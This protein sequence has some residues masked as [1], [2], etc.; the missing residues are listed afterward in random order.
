MGTTLCADRPRW[1]VHFHGDFRGQSTVGGSPGDV[2][3]VGVRLPWVEASVIAVSAV[4]GAVAGGVD[5]EPC[6]TD[7]T[8]PTAGPVSLNLRWDVVDC[9]ATLGLRRSGTESVSPSVCVGAP[10]IT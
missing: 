5:R 10:E 3:A 1:M 7:V 6:S 4:S 9:G 2:A 8:S